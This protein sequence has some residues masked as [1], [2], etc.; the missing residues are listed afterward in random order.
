MAKII[1]FFLWAVYRADAAHFFDVVYPF[2]GPT[3]PLYFAKEKPL[4]AHERTA[5]IWKEKVSEKYFSH[6]ACSFTDHYSFL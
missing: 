4:N 5:E 2:C 1:E 6:G 3:D